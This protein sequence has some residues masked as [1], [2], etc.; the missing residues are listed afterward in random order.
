M[1]R[2]STGSVAVATKADRTAYSVVG[3]TV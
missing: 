2:N 3:S 1:F